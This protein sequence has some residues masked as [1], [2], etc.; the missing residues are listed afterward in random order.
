M[1]ALA[2]LLRH[3][4][5]RALQHLDLSMNAITWR[6]AFDFTDAWSSGPAAVATV[7]PRGDP[8]GDD[9]VD[10]TDVIDSDVDTTA[11]LA[12]ESLDLTHCDL[13]S[14]PSRRR[15]ASP[16][17]AA[18]AARPLSVSVPRRDAVDESVTHDPIDD[19]TA[20][21]LRSSSVSFRVV[22]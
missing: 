3:P 5:L 6:G 21:F 9:G 10:I 13:A 17:R 20:R 2:T 7:S 19:L 1:E 8:I 12:L 4:S 11:F 22:S 16:A 14:R 18:A 15:L